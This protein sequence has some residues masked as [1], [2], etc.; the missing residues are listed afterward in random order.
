[1]P[2]WKR[3][4]VLDPFDVEPGW[5]VLDTTFFRVA[6]GRGLDRDIH[7]RVGATIHRLRLNDQQCCDARSEFAHSY[8]NGEITVDYLARHAP[9]VEREL[10]RLGQLLPRDG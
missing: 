10:R 3:R 4:E 5:F 9:F 7:E 8:W 6:A 1:M 2:S